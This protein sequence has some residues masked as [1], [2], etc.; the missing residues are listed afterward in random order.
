MGEHIKP[1]PGAAGPA[2]VMAR[3]PTYPGLKNN[4][5][6]FDYKIIKDNNNMGVDGLRQLLIDLYGP[7]LT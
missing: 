2:L 6:A 3:W 5:K 1:V 7:D 4:M